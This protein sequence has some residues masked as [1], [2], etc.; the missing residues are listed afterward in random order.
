MATLFRMWVLL[1]S[2]AASIAACDA[3]RSA[4][5]EDLLSG[6]SRPGAKR[7]MTYSC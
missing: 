6:A 5:L 2:H 3:V 7:E 4:L 1:L